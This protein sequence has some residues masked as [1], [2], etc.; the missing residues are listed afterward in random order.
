M[1]VLLPGYAQALT[2]DARLDRQHLVTSPYSPDSTGYSAKQ[3]FLPAIDEFSAFWSI[4]G[5]DFVVGPFRAIVKNT[6]TT[7]GGD[8]SVVSTANENITLT[9]SSDTT[10]RIDIIGVQVRDA[11]Y[12]GTET[13]ARVIAVEGEPTAGTPADPTLP[14][15]FLPIARATVNAASSQATIEPLR[16]RTGPAGGVLTAFPEEIDFDGECVGETQLLRA[17]SNLPERLRVWG[18]GDRWHGMGQ[19]HL[20]M[21]W[22]FSG[23]SVT[24]PGTSNPS[25]T[26]GGISLYSV[27][28]PDPGYQYRIRSYI[29]TSLNFTQNRGYGFLWVREGSSSG[30]TL[31]SVDTGAMQYSWTS[32]GIWGLLSPSVYAG[33]QTFVVGA[34]ASYEVIAYED[35]L[36]SQASLAVVPA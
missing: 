5:F 16:R 22:L 10:N 4:S 13:D 6:F 12:E 11:A 24:I 32:A 18:S 26:T 17:D 36:R 14:P 25:Q 19:I 33:Q 35:P 8:Y 20:T 31:S 3:G 28:V 2:Y 21:N 27:T 30:A 34:T 1:T 9:A 15:S 7:D 29:Q 23:T